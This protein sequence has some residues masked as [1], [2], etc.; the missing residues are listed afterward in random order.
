MANTRFE[1][2]KGD[3]C[4]NDE[5]LQLVSE[6][7]KAFVGVDFKAQLE[8]QKEVLKKKSLRAI[9]FPGIFE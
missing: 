5:M 9:H 3:C 1:L 4:K 7:L 6:E 2:L 8:E